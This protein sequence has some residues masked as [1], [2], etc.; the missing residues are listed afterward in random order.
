[1]RRVTNLEPANQIWE[2]RLRESAK[3]VLSQKSGGRGLV[4]SAT[5]DK[6]HEMLRKIFVTLNKTLGHGIEDARNLKQRHVQVLVKHW[7]SQGHS[8]ATIDVKLSVLRTLTEGLGKRGVVDSLDSYIPG[9]RHAYKRKE[10]EAQVSTVDF[11]PVWE[12]AYREDRYV[13]MQLLLMM[14]FGVA[15]EEAIQFRPVM[16][17]YRGEGMFIEVR[18][19]RDNRRPRAI[20]VDSEMRKAVLAALKNFIAKRYVDVKASVCNPERTLKQNVNRFYYILRKVGVSRKE[21]GMTSRWLF[22]GDDVGYLERCGLLN[23]E[24]HA[25]VQ[26]RQ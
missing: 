22:P 25:T 9:Y 2:K 13:G 3:N 7:T 18:N 12:R 26:P 24:V 21:M 8:P 4:S 16:D 10:R 17:D 5:R 11:W 6:R 1:M 23:A 19:G 14:S 15:I 20:A